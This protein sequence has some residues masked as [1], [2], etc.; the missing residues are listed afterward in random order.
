[1]TLRSEW[2]LTL[3]YPPGFAS[4]SLGRVFRFWTGDGDLTLSGVTYRSTVNLVQIDGVES[5][6]NETA[7]RPRVSF[8]GINN[9]LRPLF[10]ADPG[11]VEVEIGAVRLDS[12]GNWLS[13]PRVV[14]GILTDPVMQSE[15][16]TFEVTPEEL[17]IDRGDVE[18][19]TDEDHR[20]RYPDDGVFRHSRTLAD[21]VDIRWPP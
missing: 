11:R 4:N 13:M 20:R 19:W 3:E 6:L 2:L 5:R 9:R 21:G 14:R 15:L 17:D 7:N 12:D 16:Y 1:M 10:L 8:S 18:Y